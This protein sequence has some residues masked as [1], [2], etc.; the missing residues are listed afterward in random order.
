MWTGPLR[1]CFL[2]LS[3][4]PVYQQ[5]WHH[6]PE[7]REA[8]TCEIWHKSIWRALFWIAHLLWHRSNTSKTTF[9]YLCKWAPYTHGAYMAFVYHAGNIQRTH[10]VFCFFFPSSP[11]SQ[12]DASPHVLY[13]TQPVQGIV[14]ISRVKDKSAAHEQVL[15]EGNDRKSHLILQYLC[16]GI[17]GLLLEI[18]ILH[19]IRSNLAIVVFEMYDYLWCM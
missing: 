3:G 14:T 9:G 12:F 19:F 8:D 2:R 4:L 15:L 16:C 11:L 5:T 13:Q 17:Q 1:F 6:M 18:V 10:S 7:G